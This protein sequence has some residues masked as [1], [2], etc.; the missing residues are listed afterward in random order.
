LGVRCVLLTNAAGALDP[1]WVPGDLMAIADHVNLMG[2]SPLVGPDDGTLG[3]RFPDMSAAYDK[4]LRSELQD[5]ARALDIP[6]REGVY[7]AFMGPQYETPAEVR[8]ARLLGA[9]AVGMSTVPEVIALRH[10]GV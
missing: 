3:P 6:L 7:A 10:M 8:M 1:T 5:C 2:V 9:H 4:E